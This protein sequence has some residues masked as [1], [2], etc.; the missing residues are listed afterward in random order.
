MINVFIS[1]VAVA[2]KILFFV[3]AAANQFNILL[4]FYFN[5]AVSYNHHPGTTGQYPKPVWQA[6]ENARAKFAIIFW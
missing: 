1:K 5:D 3:I 4:L 6:N 2:R